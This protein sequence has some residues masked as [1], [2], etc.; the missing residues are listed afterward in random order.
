MLFERR[1]GAVNDSGRGGA[2][3]DSGSS[4][5]VLLLG[6]PVVPGGRRDMIPCRTSS[7][8]RLEDSKDTWVSRGVEMMG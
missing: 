8:Q 6:S 7:C 2:V 3:N 4:I 5:P 1:G